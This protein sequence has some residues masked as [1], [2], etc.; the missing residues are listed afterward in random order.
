MIRSRSFASSVSFALAAC[1]LAGASAYAA[2]AFHVGRAYA[3]VRDLAF[4]FVRTAAA[5][6]EKPA[7]RLEARRIELVQ[8]CAYALKL[9][10]RQRPQVRENWR[11]CPST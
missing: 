3:F 4:D 5:K 6:F 11:M 2:V 10:K 1:L 9:A 7:L 8:S